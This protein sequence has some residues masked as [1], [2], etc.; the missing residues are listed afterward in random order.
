MFTKLKK[1]W[2]GKSLQE[3]YPYGIT[4]FRTFKFKI[5][6]FFFVLSRSALVGTAVFGAFY[7]TFIAGQHYFPKAVHAEDAQVVDNLPAK[8]QEF[9]ANVLADL[10]S[11]EA[12]GYKE[13]DAPIILDSNSKMSIGLY[14]WQ[15]DSVIYYYKTLYHQTITR[16]QAV[17]IAL[18][19]TKAGNLA[20]DVIFSEGKGAKEWVNCFAR[21]GLDAK[22]AVVKELSK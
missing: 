10:R 6:R 8:I 19:E 1:I 13:S 7:A 12:K 16:K 9:K 20:H 11:C 15:I 17:E 4:K 18:D 2:K 5:R 3:T 21:K 22:V 14:M